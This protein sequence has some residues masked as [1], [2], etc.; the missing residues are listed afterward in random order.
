MNTFPESVVAKL[1]IEEG[2]L[3]DDVKQALALDGILPGVVFAPVSRASCGACTLRLNSLKWEKAL[4][5]F[6]G[7]VPTG[8]GTRDF[9]PVANHKVFDAQIGGQL[10]Q[11]D[12][13]S[14][15]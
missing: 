7:T 11:P 13:K 10:L 1:R 4:R 6:Q 9:E 3:S 14:Y 5:V 15:L 12:G 8:R 2:L